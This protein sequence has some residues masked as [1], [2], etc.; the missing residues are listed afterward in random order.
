MKEYRL[1]YL[2]EREEKWELLLRKGSRSSQ[3]TCRQILR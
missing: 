2:K 3:Q 1:E